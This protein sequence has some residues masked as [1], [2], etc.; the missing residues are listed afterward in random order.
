MEDDQIIENGRWPQKKFK[1]EDEP[2]NQYGR[3]PNKIKMEEAFAIALMNQDVKLIPIR[4]VEASQGNALFYQLPHNIFTYK[5][6][7]L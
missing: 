6:I 3:W 1:M 2:K 7:F 5:K 4:C